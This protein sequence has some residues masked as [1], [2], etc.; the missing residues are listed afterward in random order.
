M[1]ILIISAT[2]IET[3]QIIEELHFIK[4]SE[5]LYSNLDYN[6]DILITGIG[7][8]A[9]L[10]SM[11]ANINIKEYDFIINI[12]I[13]GSFS[14]N[15]KIAELVNVNSD[16]FEDIKIRKNEEWINVFDSIHNQ[17]FRNLINNTR[18]YNTSDY[19]HFFHKL[20]KVSGISVNIPEQNPVSN[21]EI[22]TMEGAAFML[23]CKHFKKNF[24]Q[25][26]GISNIILKTKRENWDF[27]SPINKYSD[28]I[29]D[30]LKQNK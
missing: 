17:H 26:R 11:F 22:E 9:T 1:K 5:I 15:L 29:I 14:E 3:K 21:Y 28:L 13:A 12:G 18:I 2:S 19:P 27:D 6:C 23:V 8:T 20:N 30:F 10:F 16:S 24:I 25:I 7:L 4:K